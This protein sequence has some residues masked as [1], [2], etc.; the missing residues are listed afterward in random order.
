LHSPRVRY[1]FAHELGH[2]FIDEHRWEL[3]NSGYL[4][5]VP[6]IPLLSQ[7]IYEKESE[8]FA[9]CLLM[10]L[11]RFIHD[12]TNEHF[13]ID[14]VLKICGKYSSLPTETSYTAGWIG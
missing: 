9:S 6:D 1:S 11:S 12:M 4:A 8:F 2:Y 3:L 10:P 7:H 5:H 14:V 13:N